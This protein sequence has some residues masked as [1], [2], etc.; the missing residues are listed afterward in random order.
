MCSSTTTIKR[1]Q[2]GTLSRV[3][4][5]LKSSAEVYNNILALGFDAIN[6]LG[7]SRAEM[8]YDGKYVRII[9]LLMHEKLP[10]LPTLRYDYSKI[11]KNFFAPEDKWE[12]VFPAVLPQWDRTARVGKTEGVYVNSTPENFK[13]HLENA[14]EII[15]DKSEEHRVLFLRSWNEW[16]EGNYVEPDLKYGHGFLDAIRSVIQ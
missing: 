8:L 16:G 11:I 1:N 3:L 7:K 5:N 14:L 15:K 10:F 13:K 6:S 2:N 4:P 12:N 9:K